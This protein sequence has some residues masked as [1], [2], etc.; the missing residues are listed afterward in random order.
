MRT[1]VE[2]LAV[3]ALAAPL[4]VAPAFAKTLPPAFGT[5]LAPEQSSKDYKGPSAEVEERIEEEKEE[6]AAQRPQ[7]HRGGGGGR[8]GRVRIQLD[9]DEDGGG[10]S[11]DGDF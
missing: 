10:D 3:A 8:G 1:L 2:L 7:P 5:E 11:I 4:A 6:R 9:G